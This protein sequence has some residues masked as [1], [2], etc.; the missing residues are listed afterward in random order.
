V[1][2]LVALWGAGCASAV[3]TERP[4]GARPR[5][6]TV[7]LTDS[8]RFAPFSAEQESEPGMREAI[9]ACEESGG[10]RCREKATPGEPRN[11]FVRGEDEHV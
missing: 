4:L 10:R 9:G 3:A 11:R 7:I 2:I 8:L 6:V 1:G 5:I